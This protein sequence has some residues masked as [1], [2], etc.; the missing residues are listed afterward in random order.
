MSWGPHA[1]PAQYDLLSFNLAACSAVNPRGSFFYASKLHGEALVPFDLQGHRG[2]R[3]LRPENTLPS[4]EAALDAGVTSIETDLH[5]TRD[6]AVVLWHDP[7]VTAAHFHPAPAG[8]LPVSALTLAELR[9]FEA[10]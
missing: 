3:G 1:F 2:A 8:P 7:L 6:G 4:F 9:R 10:V 5:L